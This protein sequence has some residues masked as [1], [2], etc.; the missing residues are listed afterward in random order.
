MLKDTI[1]IF[2]F[3]DPIE[4]EPSNFDWSLDMD[5]VDFNHKLLNNEDYERTTDSIFN[6]DGQSNTGG[7]ED[8]DKENN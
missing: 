5:E 3:Q 1:Y 7:T 2:Q 8:T 6:S 4:K